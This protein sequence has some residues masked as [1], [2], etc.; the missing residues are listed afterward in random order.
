LILANNAKN[1]NQQLAL[2]GQWQCLE[3]PALFNPR[4][5]FGTAI[6]IDIFDQTPQVFKL[7]MSAIR[8][9]VRTTRPI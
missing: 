6:V 8:H 4:E 9:K 7:V 1:N 3:K 2:R 5:V